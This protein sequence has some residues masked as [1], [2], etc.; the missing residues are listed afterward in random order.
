MLAA[1][2]G[3]LVLV[4]GTFLVL[5]GVVALWSLG[6]R[7]PMVSVL[8]LVVA[9]LV[10]ILML[11]VA[12]WRRSLRV[13]PSQVLSR[14]FVSVGLTMVALPLVLLR[15]VL[16]LVAVARQEGPQV[17]I[18]SSLMLVELIFSIVRS[19][20]L[21]TFEFLVWLLGRGVLL[22]ATRADLVK[23]SD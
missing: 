6:V 19:H 13:R 23:E 22:V 5:Q 7:V 3:P 8:R 15:M 1:G 18:R 12:R 2:I 10:V 21:L 16:L 11:E 17:L 20:F 14:L 9:M 4:P